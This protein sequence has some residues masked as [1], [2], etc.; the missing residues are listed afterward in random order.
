MP[1]ALGIKMA[2]DDQPDGQ[3]ACARIDLTPGATIIKRSQ[4]EFSPGIQTVYHLKGVSKLD[5][6]F[7]SALNIGVRNLE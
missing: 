4:G 6:L 5:C 7:N 2:Q 3:Q 1:G